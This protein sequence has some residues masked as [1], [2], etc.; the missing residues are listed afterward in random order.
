MKSVSLYYGPVF[1]FY[2]KHTAGI[3]ITVL[4]CAF[5]QLLTMYL[6]NAESGTLLG[7]N[8]KHIFLFKDNTTPKFKKINYTNN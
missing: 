1:S 7:V 8:G 5:I 6:I 4:I 3:I 2:S